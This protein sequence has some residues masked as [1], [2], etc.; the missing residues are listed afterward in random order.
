MIRPV[1]ELAR[2]VDV[3]TRKYE[4]TVNSE[5]S[6]KKIENVPFASPYCNNPQGEGLTLVPEVGSQAI[7]A[8]TSDGN[9]LVLGFIMTPGEDVYRGN[10]PF[11][12]PGD[13]MAST[14]D[15]NFLFLRRG[16]VVQIG[17]TPISQRMYIPL[18][19][20]IRDI[21]QNYR[22]DAIGGELEWKVESVNLDD[23]KALFELRAKEK[24]DDSGPSIFVRFGRKLSD[25]SALRDG[26]QGDMGVGAF[27]FP[28]Y[29]EIIIEP[30]NPGGVPLGKRIIFRLDKEGNE[31]SRVEGQSEREVA[32]NCFHR[33][34]SSFSQH[35]LKGYS[36]SVGAEV[37]AAPEDNCIKE[38]AQLNTTREAK[39]IMKDVCKFRVVQASDKI[40]LGSESASEPGVLG[41]QL[42]KWLALHSHYPSPAPPAQIAALKSI[43]SG[44]VFLE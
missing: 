22:M 25:E 17:A 38:C 5:F 6:H 12:N 15:G 33:V 7:L 4:V 36:L 37:P 20:L 18:E 31:F 3:D 24:A 41:V 11:L 10:R 19:N 26:A 14:R 2:V 39:N 13:I 34:E 23:P 8:H 42:V 27:S 43:L 44:K 40:Q 28:V 21:C 32:G 30:S 1:V 29:M 35:V 16:G 9:V